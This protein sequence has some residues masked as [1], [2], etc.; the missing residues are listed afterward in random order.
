MNTQR[1]H[2]TIETMQTT[3]RSRAAS[4]QGSSESQFDAKTLVHTL[5]IWCLLFL[6]PLSFLLVSWAGPLLSKAYDFIVNFSNQPPRLR[7]EF[8]AVFTS[9]S[10]AF[11]AI[12]RERCDTVSER[13]VARIVGAVMFAI[14]LLY[15]WDITKQ[16]ES[17]NV[18]CGHVEANKDS[19]VNIVAR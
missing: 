14:M 13:V 17:L 7:F 19:N 8:M 10:F 4:P 2:Q 1:N 18:Q 6:V 15:A 5:S 12:A 9:V 16:V 3:Q 11:A